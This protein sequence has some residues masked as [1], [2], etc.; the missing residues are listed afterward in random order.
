M[1]VIGIDPHMK[2]HTAV[3]LDAA[4][5]RSIGERTVN[6]SEA[7]HDELLRWA[8]SLDPD[9]Y[10]AIEDC[11]HVSGRL[12]RHLLP[13]GER[14]VRVPP[15][16][17]A[18]ARHSARTYG[19]SDPIDAQCVARAA[20][21][22]P[23]LP[24]AYLSGPE[25]DVRL[26]TDHRDDLVKERAR[27]QKR[28]RWNC[29][30]LEVSL[31][32]PSRVLDRYVWL[33]RLKEEL[34]AMPESTRCRIALEQISRCRQLTAEIRSLQREIADRMR[35][36]APEL[37]ALPGCSAICAAH[38]IGQTAGA[39]RFS[40]EAAFA[41][42]VGTAPL[43]VSSGKSERHRLNR[44]GNRCLNSTIHMIAVTQARMHPP[45]IAF[46][47]RKR[48]EGM[49]NR[50]ALRGLKR[51]ISRTVFKTMLRA[52]KECLAEVVQA[53]FAADSVAVAV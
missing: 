13:H 10:F 43:P 6:S 25:H 14:V 3:A 44:T 42:H 53:D 51:H 50:E 39:S 24:E 35:I 49:S 33:D 19:K 48:S 16:M 5:G 1:I 34:R 7:G 40:G 37:L 41:M 36:L 11:R 21:R 12:E 29:H 46:M 31:A 26:L 28:L 52:E 18:G 27:I 22:E 15:K 9:R 47:E 4:T 17:M 23:G 30:D 45:A 32:L 38:L 8:R 20:L 2:T